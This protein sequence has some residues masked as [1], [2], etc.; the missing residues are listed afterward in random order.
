MGDENRKKR[1]NF[2]KIALWVSHYF[3][4]DVCDLPPVHFMKKYASNPCN[5]TFKNHFQAP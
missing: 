5:F 3:S 2:W 4:F 1:I